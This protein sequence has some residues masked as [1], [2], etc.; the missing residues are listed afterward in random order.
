MRLF[1]QIIGMSGSN[2]GGGG[3][4]TPQGLTWSST[5]GTANVFYQPAYGLYDYSICMFIILASELTPGMNCINGLEYET[6]G[7]T[8]PYTYFNQ[9][10][11][12]VHTQSSFFGTAVTVDLQNLQ[13]VSDDTTVKANFDYTIANAG[14]NSISF[15]TPFQW[16]GS[17][18]ILVI[19]ENRDGQWDSGYG[20]GEV[21]NQGSGINRTA[22]L[23]QDNSYP[24]DNQVLSVNNRRINMKLTY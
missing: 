18:N 10:I 9:T 3:G 4:C 15:D 23:Y 1:E 12:L 19:H 20:W 24:S 16:N 11:R 21:L 22:F 2:A 17:D 8:T 6:N 13:G 14:W 5:T 7:Y